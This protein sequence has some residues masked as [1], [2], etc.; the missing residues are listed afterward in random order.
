MIT[1]FVAGSHFGLPDPSP[2]VTKA[3]LLLRMAGTPF[4]TAEAS[5]RKAPKGKIP[6]IEDDGRLI[7]D[8]TL[9]RFHLETRHGADFSGGYGP[10]ELAIAWSVE[11]LLEEHLYWLMLH[12]RWAVPEN[13]RRGPAT[14]FNAA[15]APLR[16]LVRAM[17]RREVRRNLWAQ[18]LARHT[19]EERAELGRRDLDSLSQLLGNSR[20]LLGE[21]ACGA[22][23]TLFA[24]LLGAACPLFESDLRPHL[25]RHGNLMAYLQRMAAE[26]YPQA[27]PQ[28]QA[29]NALRDTPAPS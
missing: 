13:F 27:A 6:Y 4:R 3:E 28:L 26:H 21:A 18:G 23:A 19:A 11:K 7:G 15:P 8:S 10:R 12:E 1:L 16:P 22:D 29:T 14:F 20:H 24:F 2:F 5:F 17:V 9:I 25:L